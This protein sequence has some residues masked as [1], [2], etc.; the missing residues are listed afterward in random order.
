VLGRRLVRTRRHQ[1]PG[2]A[3]AIGIELLDDDA[4]EE[5]AELAT[6]YTV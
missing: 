2:A 3:N 5:W 1:Q 6:H 4:V